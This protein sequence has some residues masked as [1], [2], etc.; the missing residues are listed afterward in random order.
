MTLLDQSLGALA[1]SIPGATQIFHDHKLD[2]CCGGK[3]SLREAAAGRGIDAQPIVDRLQALQAEAAG[4]GCDWRTQ[5]AG[6]LIAHLLRRFH[7]RHR[8]QLPEL[9]RLARRV[10]EVHGDRPDC[11]LGLAAHLSVMQHEL[12]SHMQKE[13]QVLFPM[14]AHGYTPA[15]EGPVAVMRHEHDEHGEALRRLEALTHDITMPRGACNTWRAL[16]LGLKTL[17]EDLMEHIHLENNILFEGLNAVSS[18]AV[19]SRQQ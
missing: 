14:L 8:E 6:D 13:E 9:I 19:S 18:P 3:H 12:E 10:E 17:R 4:D 2:F 15:L 16:Y 7:D 5:S 1:R 11:P